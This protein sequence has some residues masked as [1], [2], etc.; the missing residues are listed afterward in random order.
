MAKPM[1]GETLDRLAATIAERKSAAPD[2]SYTAS[3][4]GGGVQRCAK[5]LGE[6]AVELAIA[7]AAES[8]DRVASE[9]ADVIYHLLVLLAAR[10]IDPGAV[11]V[12]LTS[13]E[14]Q[15]GL[16]EKSSRHR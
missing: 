4:L 2:Q 11:A 12:A 13:R 5:K 1:L 10:G 8:D 15:S 9:A 3:L 7:A 14:S 6:E 16:A